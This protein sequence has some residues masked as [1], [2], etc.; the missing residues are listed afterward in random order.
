MLAELKE[1]VK[2][3]RFGR[4]ARIKEEIDRLKFQRADFTAE[5][6]DYDRNLD[7]DDWYRPSR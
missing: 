1:A 4:A 6:G 5:E 3:E 2:E 7:Q